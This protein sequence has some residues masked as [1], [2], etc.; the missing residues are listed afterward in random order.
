MCVYVGGML[1]HDLLAHNI[2][3]SFPKHSIFASPT[4]S[5]NFFSYSFSLDFVQA[6]MFCVNTVAVSFSF[7]SV[8]FFGHINELLPL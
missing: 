6:H 5:A 2:F 8:N 1:S 4:I 3:S 7:Q